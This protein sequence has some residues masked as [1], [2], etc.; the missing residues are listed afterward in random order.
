MVNFCRNGV[1]RAG[2]LCAS[3]ICLN[4]LHNEG[5]VDVFNAARTV[6]QNRPQL[7]ENLVS[8]KTTIY[9]CCIYSLLFVL[10]VREPRNDHTRWSLYLNTTPA[11]FL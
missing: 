7:I 1:S 3:S 11:H 5:E 6:L 8:S 2:V 4:K 10:L 9:N